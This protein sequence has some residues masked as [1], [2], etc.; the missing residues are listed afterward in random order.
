MT[1]EELLDNELMPEFWYQHGGKKHR[2]YPDMY[3]V[4]QN[5]FIEVKSVY[6]YEL[7]AE[8]VMAKARC[9]HACGYNMEIYVLNGKKEIVN[10]IKF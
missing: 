8:I 2:Y 7:K 10:L 3:I 1:E 9:V 6:T 4:T 5:K